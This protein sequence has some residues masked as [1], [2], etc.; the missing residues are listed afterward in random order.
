MIIKLFDLKSEMLRDGISLIDFLENNYKVN[1]YDNGL[2]I[3]RVFL[4]E[5]RHLCRPDLMSWESYNTVDYADIILKFNQITNPFSMQIDDIIMVPALSSGLK[6]YQKDKTKTPKEINDTK[7]LFLDPSKASQK[8]LE[9]LKQLQKI[10]ARRANGS[11]EVK[12]TNLLREGEQVYITDGN[13]I[14]FAPTISTNSQ[15]S[16]AISN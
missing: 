16:Q 4:V 2:Q 10:A 13:A 8:D 15:N 5:E 9:R 11:K 1:Y 3:T 12:P 6:F 7:A 14:T